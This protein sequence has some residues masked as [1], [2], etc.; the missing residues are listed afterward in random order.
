MAQPPLLPSHEFDPAL[1]PSP[2]QIAIR[3]ACGLAF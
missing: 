1:P 3:R 2:V